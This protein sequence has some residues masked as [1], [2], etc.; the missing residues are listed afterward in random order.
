MS[1][2]PRFAAW[3]FA[4]F[5]LAWP[6]LAKAGAIGH[7]DAQFSESDNGIVLTVSLPGPTPWRASVEDAGLILELR[8]MV[9]EDPPADP[10]SLV[11]QVR[12]ERRNADWSRLTAELGTP[13][14]L[15]SAEM[16]TDETG[17]ATLTLLL[18]ADGK[19]YRNA[20]ANQSD[21]RDNSARTVI[22]ID[23]GHGGFDP[24]AEAHGLKE[25]DL[26][27]GFA[28]LLK[29][30]L[31]ATGQFDVHL[32]READIF[33]P[34]EDRMTGARQ[35]GAELF[36]SLH[37]DTLGFG[38]G[39]SGL[40]IYRL[41]DDAL[42]AAADRLTERHKA[43]DI[44]GEVDLTG[45]GDDVALALVSMSQRRTAPRTAHLSATLIDAFRTADLAVNSRP[46]RLGAF[47]VLTAA[48]MPSVL[49]ELGFLS[50]A[51]DRSRLE[52]EDWQIE[53]ARALSEGL[54]RWQDEDRLLAASAAK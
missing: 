35:A 30:E 11:S 7:G 12:T 17:Q 48:D 18:E 2:I 47:A 9:W 19:V 45:T 29:E 20:V 16:M 15:V 14:R 52:S 49:I 53:A 37:A 22:A 3:A 10:E 43:D 21:T 36:L 25:A 6:S 46:E 32:T 51:A 54:L 4:V 40:T 34:L 27:L 13:M 39:A 1:S 31:T 5:L 38:Q 41:S 26:M 8:A 24:G 42:G 28:G 23:P 44:L 33:V 50:S